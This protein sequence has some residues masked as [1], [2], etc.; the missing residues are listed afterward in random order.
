MTDRILPPA[1]RS[2]ARLQITSTESDFWAELFVDLGL[3]VEWLGQA[4]DAVPKEDASA[5]ALVRLRSYAHALDELHHALARVQACRVE[6]HLKP[7]FSLEGTLAGYLSRLYGW[8]EEIGNDFERMAVA[9]RRRQP[10]SIVFSHHAVNESYAHFD[11]LTSALRHTNDVARELH[12][13]KDQQSWRAFEER[14]EELIWATDW[15]HMTLARRP[16]E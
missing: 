9:L 16:G 15:V 5:A 11:E 14:V 7:L 2:A 10:T 8:C 12:A 4:L 13:D 1:P 3:R 6:P